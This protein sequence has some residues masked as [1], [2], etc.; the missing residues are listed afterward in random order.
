MTAHP[1]LSAF[2][3]EKQRRPATITLSSGESV[4]GSFFLSHASARH[5]GPE[6]V[7][8]LMNGEP[9]FFPFELRGAGAPRTVLLNRAEVLTVRL[10]DDEARHEPGYDVATPHLVAIGLSRG[11]RLMGE[12]RVYGPGGHDRLSDWTRD[13]EPFRYLECAHE[14]LLV[15]MRHVIDVS[16]ALP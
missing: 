12:V 5:P 10:P 3:V 2:R 6:R 14:T 15:N 7:A 1:E 4:E 16:E 9:G 8:E 11:P 13:P